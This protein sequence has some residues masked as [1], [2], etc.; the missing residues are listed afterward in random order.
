MLGIN[1]ELRRT[2]FIPFMLSSENCSIFLSALSRVITYSPIKLSRCKKL[3]A[4]LGNGINSVLQLLMDAI[5]DPQK[6]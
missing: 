4:F 3:I 5:G 2:E 6:T 1:S